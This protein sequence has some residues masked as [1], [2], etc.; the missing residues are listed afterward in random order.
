MTSENPISAA[1]DTMRDVRDGRY[2]VGV[3]VG[4]GSARAGIFDLA[5]GM[6]A[7]AKRDITLFHASGSIVEQ[8]SSE[9]WNA[10]CES[11]KAELSQAA[12]SPDQIDSIGRAE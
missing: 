6:M 5:V 4:T 7:S 12:R 1:T 8:S 9:I 3:D 11:V 10:V 2:V